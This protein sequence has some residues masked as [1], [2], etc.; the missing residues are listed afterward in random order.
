MVGDRLSHSFVFAGVAIYFL[1]TSGSPI[2]SYLAL[3]DAIL[4]LNYYYAVDIAIA[5]GLSPV[6]RKPKKFKLKGVPIRLGLYEPVI[7]GFVFLAPLGLIKVH[8]VFILMASLIGTYFQFISKIRI[9]I[10][11]AS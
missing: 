8:I 2:W 4:L 7:Y 9:G 11:R 10:N 5:H 3:I 1:R 6:V